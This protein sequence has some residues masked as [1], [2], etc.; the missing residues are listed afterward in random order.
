MALD[1]A[2]S[3]R[4]VDLVERRACFHFTIA[5]RWLQ[6]GVTISDMAMLPGNA[7]SLI[8]SARSGSG[9][10]GVLQV[11]DNGT[12]RP[13]EYHGFSS[14]SP[15]FIETIDENRLWLMTQY[16]PYGPLEVQVDDDGI[17]AANQRPLGNL[18]FSS[19]DMVYAND[20]LYMTSGQVVD[21][22]V[23]KLL[24]T[25]PAQGA[26]AI[27]SQRHEA[28]FPGTSSVTPEVRVY[29]TREF[30]L[31]RTMPVPVPISTYAS[32]TQ[33]LRWGPSGLVLNTSAGLKFMKVE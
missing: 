19:A 24:G 14:S 31:L 21:P 17:R 25:F 9:S 7:E 6:E 8:V 12:P 15:T 33:L 29:D 20:V 2:D 26:M 11:L 18:R 4:V 27:D 1:G 16:Y 28:Y 5:S 3:V 23:P 13:V 30:T 10:D 22:F 32:I